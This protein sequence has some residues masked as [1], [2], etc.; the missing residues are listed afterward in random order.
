MGNDDAMKSLNER[1]GLARGGQ[2]GVDHGLLEL[3]GISVNAAHVVAAV[4]HEVCF[5][6]EPG[7]HVVCAVNFED[8]G[9]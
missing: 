2:V 7:S 9:R 8:K 4:S 3:A 6:V 5:I 1:G